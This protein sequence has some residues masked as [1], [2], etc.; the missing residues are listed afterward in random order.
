MSNI[1]ERCIHNSIS[2]NAATI[3]NFKSAYKKSLIQ[4]MP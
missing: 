4:I 3:S 1:Y 2:S